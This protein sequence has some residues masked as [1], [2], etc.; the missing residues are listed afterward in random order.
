MRKLILNC[1]IDPGDTV[2]FEAEGSA[3][4]PNVRVTADG[5]EL[6]V[7]SIHCWNL[8][9]AK[10]LHAWLGKLIEKQERR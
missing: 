6:P 8:S 9:K 7:L 1:D 5:S 4:R 2:T 3:N 10:R